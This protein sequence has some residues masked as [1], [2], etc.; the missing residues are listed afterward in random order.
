MFAVDDEL[1]SWRRNRGRFAVAALTLV[2][3]AGAPARASATSLITS[4]SAGVLVNE[5]TA[6]PQTS[7]YAT[8]AGAHPDVAF[9]KFT[10]DTSLG[11]AESVRVDLPPGLSVN[12]Q[13]IPRCSA[14]GTTLNTCP[15][16]SRV[17]TSTVTIANI[18]LIGKQT[19]S[20][21]VYN[22]TPPNGAPADYAF[23][24][25]VGALFTIRTDLLGGVRYYP[26][27]GRPADYG[28]YFTINPISNL[29]GTSLE[30]S[31]LIF[32]GAPE[33]HNG[34]GAPN[35]AFLSNPTTCSGPQTTYISAATY[36]P[37]ASGTAAFTTP[38]GASGCASV[39]FSPTVSL[40]PNTT[41]RD[42]PNGIALDLHVPQNQNPAATATSHLREASLTLPSGMS[43]NPAA[44]NGLQACSDA[45]FGAGTN[46][47]V[48]C[49]VA[50]AVGT[51]EIATPVLASALTGNVYVGE[52]H[53][54]N[55]YRVLIDAENT[56]SGVIVRLV[57]S[58]TADPLTGRLTTTVV[59]NPQ[60]PFTDLKL[61]FKSGASALFANA[62]TCAV[63]T[64]TTSL[65][66]YSG[67]PAATPSSS[68]TVDSNGA[69]GACPS[70][71][72]FAPAAAA[73]PSSTTA[74]ASTNLALTLAR[75]DSEQTLSSVTTDLPDGM[76][77]NLSTLTLCPEPAAAQG[78]CT[79]TSQIGTTTVTAGAGAS[80]LSL[81]GTVYLT[82]PYKGAPFGLSIVVPAIAGP[83]NLG[84]VVVRASVDLDTAHGRIT[85]ATDPL[86]TIL[87][88]IPL[89]LR[90][91]AVMI[92]R[93]GFLENAASCAS[94]AI[95]GSV[96]STAAQTQ[97]F[98]SPL[99][100]TGCESL[101]FAPTLEVTPTSTQRDAS[102]G[103]GVDLHLPA[104]S[105]DLQ[106][107]VLQ[108]PAGLTL[109][110]AIA[111]GLGACSDAQLAAGTSSPV[112]CPASAAIGSV[113]IN[114]PLL[115]TPLTGSL[116][117]GE[118]LSNEPESGQE[119]RIFLDAENAAYGVSVRL[120]G[121]LSADTTT[122]QLT[123]TFAN[124]PPIPFSD[125]R[126]SLTGGPHAAL[127]A[128]PGCGTVTFTST[129]KP[130]TGIAATPSSSYTVD[131][132][133][134]G[135]ACPP[136][137]PFNL[138]QS[139][140]DAPT[141]AAADT[142]FTLQLARADGN[143]YLSRVR[144]VLPVGLLGRIATVTPCPPAPADAGSCPPSS[145][146][147]TV[148]A[149][150]GTGSSPL[151]LPGAV[152][153][154][155]PYQGAPYGLSITVPAES[156]GPF[157]FGAVVTRAG[158]EV[159]EHTAAVTVTT[160]P[161]PTIIGGV[162]LR[163]KALTIDISRAG[164]MLNPTSCGAMATETLLSSTLGATQ[165]I[166][167]P[168]QTTA[169]QALAFE[170]S[171]TAVTSGQPSKQNGASLEVD[172][173]FPSEH[174]ANVASISTT[175][176]SQLPARLSTL[177]KAC[178]E[179]SFLAAPASCPQGAQ[180]GQ[181][182][183]LTPV[184]PDPVSGPAYLVATGG[185]AFPDLYLILSGDGLKLILHGHTVIKSGVITATFPTIPD[186]PI[187]HVA[188]DLPQGPYSALAANGA[189]CGETLVMGT[190]ITAHNGRQLSKQVTI[191]ASGCAAT[192]VGGLLLSSLRIA[193]GR[194]AAAAKGASITALP[195]PQRGGR[196]GHTKQLGATIS[197]RDT[198]AAT[199]TLLVLR[200]ARGERHGR[201][202]L[203]P[204]KHRRRHGRPCKRYVRIG[205]FMHHDLAGLNRF[206]FSGRLS[207]RKLAP[208]SYR[209]EV[210]AT[211][212]AGSR[213]ATV[214]ARFTVKRH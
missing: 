31:E 19:V 155:G 59:S 67:T 148:L 167:T 35:N 94:T 12:P 116:F 128:P 47:A 98:S 18:P 96:G 81:P 28:E 109:N 164:F 1:G 5:N 134:A 181:A 124:T 51:V 29:L 213:S 156:V 44:G 168:F 8:Q 183:V 126:L 180:I 85:I 58:V 42:K 118:P 182:S 165:S 186:V 53:E 163:L 95:T 38:V 205:S 203:A 92:N 185:A 198:Q 50:S 129:L 154:T 115:P 176:P 62:L 33:E 138:T 64:T 144:T 105:A 13:A 66:P 2:L 153:L 145:Q 143:Q 26:S 11:S 211:G 14:T 152:Y 196:H 141:S 120:V 68:F 140:Q 200:S 162:P 188:L 195:R 4:F 106:G 79:A 132:N 83:Y 122:G 159:D 99:T 161:I 48:A 45:Q 100:L 114:T 150:L 187:S 125:I 119:Y 7:D 184:L 207:G 77:A 199:T 209:L 130:S 70:T 101:S 6:N 55:P 54:G 107:A 102:V 49:P 201:R 23:Q 108:L 212:A 192:K 214:S 90:S 158:I 174:Q 178:P 121:A 37:V 123:A 206:R 60:L 27:N 131:D 52:P 97:P 82:G 146:I 72:T 113:E 36:A 190:T 75:A 139:T 111:S 135:G 103:L 173:S 136:S 3:L 32:W 194:F 151:E 149:A 21:A 78:T 169:C 69:G 34:G 91:V 137:S 157:N 127:A 9:T 179:A 30:K 10:L 73:N 46:A 189:M 86:P 93:P 39:P 40:T 56:A 87:Q 191:A 175:L 142:A 160:S 80:P 147:G 71:P 63:A 197:Y 57:G 133:G 22:M 17:G 170:P 89:R 74:G 202:C 177:Q 88:G 24:V 84:T 171:L 43:L 208:G 204:S 76:L 25:T 117:V 166:S 112:T 61:S 104:K 193:P 210:R 15:A 41:Q 65:A 16:S 20:G 172:L 110:P